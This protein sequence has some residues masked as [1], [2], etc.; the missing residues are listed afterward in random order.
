MKRRGGESVKWQKLE[1]GRRGGGMRWRPTR[2]GVQE[3]ECAC[4]FKAVFLSRKKKHTH[5]H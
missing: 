5:T 4:I 1:R 3:Y 2:E